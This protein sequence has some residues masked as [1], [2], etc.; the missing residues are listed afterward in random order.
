MQS[1]HCYTDNL[2]QSLQ[3]LVNI[4]YAPNIQS[5]RVQRAGRSL[6][7]LASLEC[8][9]CRPSQQ[10]MS[11]LDVRMGLRNLWQM[12]CYVWDD[13][14]ASYKSPMFKRFRS[15][16]FSKIKI[17]PASA[18]CHV[19]CRQLFHEPTVYFSAARLEEESDLLPGEQCYDKLC[20]H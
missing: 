19:Q 18:W 2:N 20:W 8:S 10:T 16:K 12:V 11:F 15:K 17:P 7:K 3:Q 1:T 14:T 13:C 4:A 5:L 9:H 6:V